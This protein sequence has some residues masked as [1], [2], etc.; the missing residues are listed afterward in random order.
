MSGLATVEEKNEEED[1]DV[2]VKSSAC[3]FAIL[4]RFSAMSLAAL[5]ARG[6]S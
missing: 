2:M 3:V 5:V 4:I 6:I 1:D